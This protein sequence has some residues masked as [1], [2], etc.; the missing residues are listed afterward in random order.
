[1]TASEHFITASASLISRLSGMSLANWLLNCLFT[2]GLLAGAAGLMVLVRRGLRYGA[3]HVPGDPSAEKM[4]R[5]SRLSRLLTAILRLTIAAGAF[6]GL[7]E[8]WGFDLIGWTGQGLGERALA[9]TFHLL[10]LATAAIIAFEAAGLVL[11]RLL[12]K[13]AVEALEDRRR[14]QLRTLGPLLQGLVKSVILIIAVLM[15]LSEM[16]VKIGPLLAGAGVV[17]IALGFGAQTLVK[18][19]LTGVFLLAEDVVSVGDVI[20]IGESGGLVEQMTLRSIQLRDFDGTLHTFPYSEAQ[21][22]HNLTK[23][24]SYYVFDLRVSYE[25]NIDDALEIMSRTGQQ[26]QA[27]P[28]Y[29]D[30]ILEPIEVVGVDSLADS[31][32]VLKARIKTRP[33]EQWAVGREYNRR[34]KSAFDEAGVEIPLPHMKVVLPKSQL[35]EFARS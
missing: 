24:F 11:V 27:D 15:A 18:D 6:L 28:D 1:L 12:E 23:S 9:T 8:I 3:R 25:S 30:R 10:L 35:S 26:M 17:G 19:F 5:V 21:V 7:A 31:G 14:A 4:V 2:V 22:V 32:V 13:I 29:A 33:V 34:I 20:R 16:D